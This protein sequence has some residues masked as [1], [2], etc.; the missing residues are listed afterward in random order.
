[1]TQP[2]KNGC[3]PLKRGGDCFTVILS[4]LILWFIFLI[5]NLLFALTDKTNDFSCI[6]YTA[7]ICRL[8]SNIIIFIIYERVE[9]FNLSLRCSRSWKSKWLDIVAYLFFIIIDISVVL[10]LQRN[11]NHQ[12]KITIV[13]DGIASFLM[14]YFVLY[15]TQ[16]NL[17]TWHTSRRQHE[18]LIENRMNAMVK[19]FWRM[20]KTYI[21]AEPSNTNSLLEVVRDIILLISLH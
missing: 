11:W 6:L 8:I 4:L 7:F 14:F 5:N 15:F 13:L 12:Q 3:S 16:G 21:V 18:V 9:P 19:Q 17:F 10:I 20:I 1:M 2:L